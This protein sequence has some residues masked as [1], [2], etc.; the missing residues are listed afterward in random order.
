MIFAR[1]IGND[2]EFFG[3]TIVIG[4]FASYAAAE[5]Y[6]NNIKRLT[7]VGNKW[8]DDDWSFSI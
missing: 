1:Y 4:G 3:E 8:L 6:L 5:E 2:K 7:K